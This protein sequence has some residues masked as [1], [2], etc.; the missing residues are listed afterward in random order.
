MIV[1][2][3]AVSVRLV[4]G[5]KFSVSATPDSLVSRVRVTGG[6]VE[7]VGCEYGVRRCV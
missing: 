6:V 3:Q 2:E 7:W 5:H 1:Q 4:N